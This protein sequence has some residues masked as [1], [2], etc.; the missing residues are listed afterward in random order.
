M[1]QSLRVC[2]NSC[3]LSQWCYSVISSSTSLFSSCF[4]SFPASGSLLKEMSWVKKGNPE[5]FIGFDFIYITFFFNMLFI[6]LF[7]AAL[8]LHCCPQAF[9]SCGLWASHC[10]GLSWCGAWAPGSEGSVVMA[11]RLWSSG[12]VE[13]WMGLV[14]LPHL[15]GIFLEQGSN[16]CLLHWQVHILETTKQSNREQ[17]VRGLGWG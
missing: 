16:L 14:A 7:L 5:G 1:S 2:S 4:Q 17:V 10:S 6:C 8:G 13:W 9:S 3:S 15:P 12:P 11:H